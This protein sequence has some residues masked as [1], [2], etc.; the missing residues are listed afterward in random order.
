MKAHASSFGGVGPSEAWRQEVFNS[1]PRRDI[2]KH[3]KSTTRHPVMVEWTGLVEYVNGGH[4][5]VAALLLEQLYIDGYVRRWK[6]QPFDLQELG[7]PNSVP[8]FLVELKDRTLHI[9]EV[10]A[11]RF[12]SPEIEAKFDISEKFLEPLGFVF[13]LWTNADKLSSATSHTVAELER[14]RR[15]PAP[16]EI[17]SE[18]GKKAAEFQVIG[19]LLDLYSWDDVLSAAAFRAFHIDFTQP[20]HENSPIVR[21]HSNTFYSH[22]FAKRDESTSWWDSLPNTRSK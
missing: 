14:G 16:P 18:I 4:E 5:R 13:H 15:F 17:I 10:K 3:G 9:I 22:I 7:G 20:I 6:T 12:V 19:Q 11:K 8:D 2:Q 1:K 21:N